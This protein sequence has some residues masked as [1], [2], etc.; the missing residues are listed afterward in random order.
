[1]PVKAVRR[2]NRF[3]V[4]ETSTRKIAKTSLG[5]PRDGGGHRTEG[6]AKSQARAIN[7]GRKK[8]RS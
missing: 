2:G 8:K 6:K 4:I 3:R 7:T 5:N 1:M